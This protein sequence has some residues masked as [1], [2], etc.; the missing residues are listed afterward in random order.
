MKDNKLS[1][2]NFVQQSIIASAAIPVVGTFLQSCN[3]SD[4]KTK[5]ERKFNT[6]Y[7]NENLSRVA[8]PIGGMGA[9]MFCMEGS[10]AISHMSVRHRPELSHEPCM[11][12]S[13][14]VK[15]V[16]NRSKVLERQTPA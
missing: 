4:G 5:S 8:F 12:A 2:R 6:K 1:R 15:G 10:G 11:F 13:V 14:H 9:G 3:E 7:E 16:E